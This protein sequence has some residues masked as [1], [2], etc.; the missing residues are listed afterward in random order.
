MKNKYDCLTAI[1]YSDPKN[2]NDYG[3]KYTIGWLGSGMCQAYRTE[4]GFKRFL[5][6][7]NLKIDYI[8]EQKHFKMTHLTIKIYHFKPITIE[9]PLPFWNIEDVKDMEPFVG[10]SNGSYVVC[11]YKHYKNGVKIM[12]PNPNAKNVY[13]ELNYFEMAKIWG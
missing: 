11:Y 13:T 4:E 3:Y 2:M 12:R 7:Y 5:K 6:I 10:L 8:E 1:E 9:E